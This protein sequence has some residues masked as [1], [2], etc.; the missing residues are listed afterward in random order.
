MTK[1]RDLVTKTKTVTKN[2]MEKNI[3]D[4]FGLWQIKLCGEKKIYICDN[5]WF[6]QVKCCGKAILTKK[7]GWQ[8]NNDNKLICKKKWKK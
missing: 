6:W 5:F 3:C 4:T 1:K 7:I 8:N 2:I